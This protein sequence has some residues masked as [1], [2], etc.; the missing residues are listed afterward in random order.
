M[1]FRTLDAKVRVDVV[2]AHQIH[3]RTMVHVRQT[4]MAGVNA[5]VVQATPVFAVNIK[6]L[7]R[8]WMEAIV[9][10]RNR[11]CIMVIV[12]WISNM[13]KKNAQRTEDV[14]ELKVLVQ[15]DLH[16]LNFA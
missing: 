9:F 3:V 4:V 1:D 16:I 8:E 5:F 15:Q 6:M 2:R 10:K 12:N 13:Q 14:L 11:R 7:T